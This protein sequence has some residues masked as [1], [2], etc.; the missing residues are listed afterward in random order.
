MLNKVNSD[1]VEIE[2]LLN[3]N[4]PE[5]CTNLITMVTY[6]IYVGRLNKGLLILITICYPVILFFTN[7]I[8]KRIEEL[9]KI[10]KQKTDVITEISQECIN[11]ML[12]LRTFGLEDYFQKR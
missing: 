5:I 1:I 12:V 7:K 8:V 11:G 3:E 4:I 2:S 10:Y 6:A 9:K